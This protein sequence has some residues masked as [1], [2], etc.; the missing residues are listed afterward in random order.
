[1]SL[2][3]AAEENQTGEATSWLRATEDWVDAESSENTPWV[4][5][6]RANRDRRI[7]VLDQTAADCRAVEQVCLDIQTLTH[8]PQPIWDVRHIALPKEALTDEA[9]RAALNGALSAAIPHPD[10]PL[11]VFLFLP[12]NPD[13]GLRLAYLCIQ[14]LQA[15]ARVNPLQFYCC[16]RA[17]YEHGLTTATVQYEALSGL[18]RSAILETVGHDYRSIVFPG[19]RHRKRRR[20]N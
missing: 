19:S 11:T 16:H 7:L 8:H 5:R 10:T 2:P 20:C 4:E 9:E 6:I 13:A 14:A 12:D 1:M 17:D 3:D 15:V 18:L